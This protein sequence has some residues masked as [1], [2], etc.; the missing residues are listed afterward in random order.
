VQVIITVISVDDSD[1]SILAI[2]AASLALVV[3]NIPWRGPIG[4]V[5]I[6]KYDD[7]VLKINPSSKLHEE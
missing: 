6:G 4:A 1:P 2:N 5:R 7:D 3:S